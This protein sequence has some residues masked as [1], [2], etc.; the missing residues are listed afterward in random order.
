[1]TLYSLDGQ[2]PE[3]HPEAWVAPSAQ[4]IG[5]VRIMAGASIWFGAVLRGDNEWIEIGPGSNVQDNAVAHTDPGFPLTIGAN[6][7]VGHAAIVHGCTIEDGA[8]VGM[9]ATVLNGARI[10]AGSLIGAG[11]V[12]T[13]RKEFPA[14]SLVL[15]A[16][17]KVVREL[18][19]NGAAGL[20]ETAAGY[21]ARIARFRTGLDV[22][23]G[24]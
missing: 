5:K 2:T 1:M 3:V 11:A 19:D 9:A 21:R 12:V 22:V 13:E 4:V 16:P 15:G 6:C 17:G 23:R 8:L 7:T 20:L 10:G 24:Q 14:R 18:D